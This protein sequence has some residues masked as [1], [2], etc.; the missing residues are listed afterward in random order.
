[1]KSRSFEV[2]GHRIV[3]TI[4]NC[5][6][7]TLTEEAQDLCFESIEDFLCGADPRDTTSLVNSEPTVVDYFKYYLS[8]LFKDQVDNYKV[9]GDSRNNSVDSVGKTFNIEAAFTVKNALI[10]TRISYTIHYKNS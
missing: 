10:A 2:R 8:D 9:V 1:M 3:E 6:R 4:R 7:P 5:V